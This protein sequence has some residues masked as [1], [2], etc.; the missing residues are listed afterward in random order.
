MKNKPVN[1]RFFGDFPGIFSA[2]KKE[3]INSVSLNI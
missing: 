1:T 2:Y 3:V